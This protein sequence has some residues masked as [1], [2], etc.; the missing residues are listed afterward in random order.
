[1]RKGYVY[2]LKD[3]DGII[4][5]IG[6]TANPERREYYHRTIRKSNKLQ[7]WKDDNPDYIMEVIEE[8]RSQAET[9]RREREIYLDMKAKGEELLNGQT[10][11]GKA[12]KKR[13]RKR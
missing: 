9:Y 2:V 10:P 8:C 7:R 13:K 11:R 6:A 5:Y 12:P 4:A 1:M 3:K